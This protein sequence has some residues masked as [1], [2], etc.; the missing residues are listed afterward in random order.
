MV[1][2][3][4]NFLQGLTLGRVIGFSLLGLG[5]VMIISQII[6][7]IF[8]TQVLA[9]GQSFIFLVV[10]AALVIIFSI[11]LNGV[12]KENVIGLLFLGII[13]VALF[14]YLP[15]FLP[16]FF[17]EITLNAITNLQSTLGIP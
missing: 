10:I 12:T 1:Q 6:S 11:F 15:K 17:N 14:I 5:I 3:I 9:L 16:E 8:G 7:S 4:N 13:I 2:K